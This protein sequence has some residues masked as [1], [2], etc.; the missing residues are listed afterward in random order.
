MES[1]FLILFGICISILGN[2]NWR[3]NIASIH[4]YNRT[5]ITKENA[6]K[7]GKAMGL[8]TMIMGISM[9]LTGLL[10]MIFD[11]ESLWYITLVGIIVGLAFMLYGQFKYNK[12]IF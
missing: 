3:G 4:W 10:Q 11:M 7:Y 9:T 12:G 8:G 2:F 6:K 5:R 1:I